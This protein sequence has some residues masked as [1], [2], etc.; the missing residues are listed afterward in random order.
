MP[1]ALTEKLAL[2]LAITDWPAGWVVMVGAEGAGVTVSV[3][4]V[5]KVEPRGLPTA[6][7]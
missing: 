4:A 1:L 3:A 5:L 2:K 7:R 6:T